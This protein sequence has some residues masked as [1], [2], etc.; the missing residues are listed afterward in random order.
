MV[1]KP[2]PVVVKQG[3]TS[4]T[5]QKPKAQVP[6]KKSSSKKMLYIVLFLIVVAVLLI[7]YFNSK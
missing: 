2:E 1:Q 7:L 5:T 4:I 6:A 3:T